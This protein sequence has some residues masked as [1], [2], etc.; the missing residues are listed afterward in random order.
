MSRGVYSKKSMVSKA[1]IK[2][3]LKDKKHYEAI[4][5]LLIDEIA[6]NQR[7]MAAAKRLLTDTEGEIELLT[8]V[9]AKPGEVS[10]QLN[11]A[12]GA[13]NNA[14]GNILKI[15]GKLGLSAFDRKKIGITR[16]AEGD[17]FKE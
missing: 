11:H 5:D 4:D 15:C 10:M 16:E 3:Y 17:G 7:V 9:A 14:L 8:N 1:K 6:Y 12:V 2:K 13:Y